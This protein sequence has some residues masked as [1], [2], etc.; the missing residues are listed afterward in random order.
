M[1]LIRPRPFREP[2]RPTLELHGSVKEAL[3]QKVKGLLQ[4]VSSRTSNDTSTL[5][6]LKVSVH[7]LTPFDYR[8]QLQRQKRSHPTL[9]DSL[10][11]ACYALLSN[12]PGSPAKMMGAEEVIDWVK[13]TYAISVADECDG[14]V[15]EEVVAEGAAPK[16]TPEETY[17]EKGQNEFFDMM[18]ARGNTLVYFDVSID[19]VEVGALV[20]ELY[21][22]VAPI[23]CEHFLSFVEG[24]QAHP[25]TDEP[26]MYSGTKITR[27]IKN[28]WLQAGDENFIIPHAHRG[29]LSLVNTGPHS[30]YSQ[31]MFTFKE[32]PYLDRKYVSIGRCVDGL[33]VLEMLENVPTRFE[34]PLVDVVFSDI[35][36]YD[37]S[38]PGEGEREE[39]VEAEVDVAEANPI[40]TD[41]PEPDA[42][43]IEAR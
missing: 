19:H 31:F 14:I 26:L 38:L 21:N 33:K 7:P 20:V 41:A 22:N 3:Y 10:H 39:A 2:P 4:E 25:E 43:A 15:E 11:P 18:R 13:A 32:I 24:R 35:G 30:A 40:E 9:V 8:E 17:L 1:S 28:G 6:S 16:Q 29:Q 37:I 34:R 36:V 27:L 42:D 23:T 5:S 12:P